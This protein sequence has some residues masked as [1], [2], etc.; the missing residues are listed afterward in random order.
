MLSAFNAFLV[1]IRRDMALHINLLALNVLPENIRQGLE[2]RIQRVVFSAPSGN[3]KLLLAQR[4]KTC[5]FFAAQ[6][7][8]SQEADVQN[9]YNVC[10]VCISQGLAWQTVFHVS[11]ASIRQALV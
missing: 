2:L 4:T 8:I 10:K 7:H 3:I 1:R 6:A 5:A 9:A 11:V